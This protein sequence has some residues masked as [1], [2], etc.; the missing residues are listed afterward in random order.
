MSSISEGKQILVAIF[1]FA[2]TGK[3][4]LMNAQ[5][6]KEFRIHSE[7]AISNWHQVM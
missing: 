4:L 6:V 2:V 7:L 5:L 3:L 1:G